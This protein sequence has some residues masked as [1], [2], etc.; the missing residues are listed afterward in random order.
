MNTW[1]LRLG[2]V[3]FERETHLSARPLVL[4]WDTLIG[5]L[6]IRR[7]LRGE[8]Q[9]TKSSTHTHQLMIE[10]SSLIRRCMFVCLLSVMVNSFHVK[11]PELNR[12]SGQTDARYRRQETDCN[13]IFLCS[14]DWGNYR[15]APGPTES[16]SRWIVLQLQLGPLIETSSAHLRWL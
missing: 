8:G 12:T 4:C 5:V 16:F 13:I 14:Y 10:F 6:S 9:E 15:G 1:L 11:P 2:S 3:E 7:T